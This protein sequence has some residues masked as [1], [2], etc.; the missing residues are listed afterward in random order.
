MRARKL[1]SVSG[2]LSWPMGMLLGLA[3]IGILGYYTWHQV[4]R[5]AILQIAVAKSSPDMP[6]VNALAAA[7]KAQHMHPRLRVDAVKDEAAA[8]AGVE[9]GRDELY[10]TRSDRAPARKAATLAVLHRDALLVFAVAGKSI[11][12]VSNLAGRKVGL[13]PDDAANRGVLASALAQYGLRPGDL[14]LSGGPLSQA[15]GDFTAAR[16]DVAVLLAPLQSPETIAAL[17]NLATPGPRR[18]NLV[19]V[20]RA[21]GLAARNPAFRKIE[22]P[23]GFVPAKAKVPGEDITTPGVETLLEA[24]A[25]L[26]QTL[27]ADL[28]RNLFVMRPQIVAQLPLALGIDKPD[29]DK[30][31]IRAVQLGAAAWYGDTDKSFLDR[32]GDFF[33]LGA[34]ILGGIGSALAAMI[35]YA[36]RS[37]RSSSGDLLADMAEARARAAAAHSPEDVAAARAEIDRL[38]ARLLVEIE[39]RPPDSATLAGLRFAL[40]EARHALVDRAAA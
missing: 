23:E 4:G 18:G 7:M 28:T 17:Q 29:G 13:Y 37:K 35:G 22:L 26:D 40:E 36:R 15:A 12:S 8:V 3:A 39:E 9:S 16:I 25:D 10:V 11:K 21:G 31:S 2:A 5:A 33:Y 1:S 27:A 20:N 38:A 6:L 30:T 24:R 19:D 14:R 32:Y 34:M